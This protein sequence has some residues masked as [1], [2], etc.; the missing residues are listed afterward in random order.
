V[1]AAQDWRREVKRWIRKALGLG[2]WTLKERVEALENQERR[3][4]LNQM[5]PDGVTVEKDWYG[6]G[7]AVKSGPTHHYFRDHNTTRLYLEGI[8]AGRSGDWSGKG[9]DD[10]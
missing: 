8:V 7:W 4:Q 3:R 10:E 2:H 5:A 6:R 1:A 9:A